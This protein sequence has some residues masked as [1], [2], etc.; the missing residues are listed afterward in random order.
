[1]KKVVFILIATMAFAFTACNRLTDAEKS[2]VNRAKSMC[3]YESSFVLTSVESLDA[4]DEAH[5][6]YDTVYFRDGKEL[7][8]STDRGNPFGGY[9]ELG[10]FINYDQFYPKYV[11]YDSIAIFRVGN[12][13]MNF[14]YV[15]VHFKAKNAFAMESSEC[16]T[17]W[18]SNEHSY[19]MTVGEWVE[20]HPD[21]HIFISGTK[22][23]KLQKTLNTHEPGY[24]S[25]NF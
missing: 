21:K 9:Y 15:T 1:M 2:A 17:F 23:D 6:E 12:D 22:F 8:N 10:D 18:V 16:V 24:F 13:A 25:W 19:P 20:N 14:Q 4:C 7:M 5:W 3:K 11:K